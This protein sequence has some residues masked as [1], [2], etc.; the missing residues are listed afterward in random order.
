MKYILNS[1]VVTTFGTYRYVP[2]TVDEAKAWLVAG[3]EPLSC[4]GYKETILAF[5]LVLGREIIENRQT[6]KMQPGDEALVFR[7]TSRVADPTQKGG[8][9]LQTILDNLEIGLLTRLE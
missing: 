9:G 6:V 1:A 7:L 3:P 8:V 2:L 5:A 4:V